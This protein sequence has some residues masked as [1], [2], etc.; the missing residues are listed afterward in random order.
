MRHWIGNNQ[1]RMGTPYSR[2]HASLELVPLY[3]I[4]SDCG[5]MNRALAEGYDMTYAMWGILIGMALMFGVSLYRYK[6]QIVREQH[7]RG[8]AKQRAHDR[9]RERY[10]L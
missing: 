4:L 8:S 7:P 6:H 10:G 5:D 1:I 3:H 9:L 2:R